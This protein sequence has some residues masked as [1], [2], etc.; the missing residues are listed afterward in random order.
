MFT[1]DLVI[2]D[3]GSATKPGAVGALTYASVLSHVIDRS[4]RRVAASATTTPREL[5]IAHTLSGTGF[6]QRCRS[7][8]RYDF[9]RLDTDIADT[10][11][12]T[13]SASGQLVLDRP[14]QSG[15]FITTAHLQTI[16]GSL[17]DVLCVSGQL[18]KFLNMEA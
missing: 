15:G 14:I 7:L 17:I 4:K 18:D 16:I 12:V 9:T 2:T 11:G 13:P 1:S 10:G 5:S 8:I 6:K 3:S